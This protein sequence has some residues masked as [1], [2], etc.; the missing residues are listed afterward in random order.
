MIVGG[1]MGALAAAFELTRAPSA[2]ERL[3][4]TLLQPGWVLGGKGASTRNADE[5]HRIE[6]HGFHTWGGYYEEAFRLMNECYAELDRPRD[7]PLA[8]LSDAFEKESRLTLAEDVGGSF[9][10]WPIRMPENDAVPGYGSRLRARDYVDMARSLL[11]SRT[12]DVRGLSPLLSSL[13]DALRGLPA[14]A[15][16]LLRRA[17]I[18]TDFLRTIVKGALSDRLFER[19]A[20]SVADEDWSAWL[21]RHGGAE[22]TV[23]SPL[24][25]GMYDLL[26]AF[27]GG[28]T[29]A[30]RLSAA[31]V[32]PTVFKF[33][34]G[35]H[36]AVLWQMKAG[37]GEVV[38]APL[39][40]VLRR[41]GVRFQFFH[42]LRSLSPSHDGRSIERLTVQRSAT[43]RGGEYEPLVDLDGLPVWPHRPLRQQLTSED[44]EVLVLEKGE[45]FDAVV[46]GMSLGGLRD[47]SRDLA[48]K[49]A[50]WAA[51][52]D[53]V[54][55]V[56]TQAMQLWID[57]TSEELG[58]TNRGRVLGGYAH[59]FNTWADMSHLIPMERFGAGQVRSLA[60]L[61]GPLCDGD[62]DAE[63]NARAWLAEHGGALWPDGPPAL[64]GRIR[65]AYF[66]TNGAGS[67]RYVQSTPGSLGYRLPPD[68][69]G[70]EN[71]FLAGDWVQT[72]YNIGT[73]EAA[74]LGG[75]GAARAAADRLRERS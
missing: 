12:P 56:A 51:M 23:R 57:R 50:R 64:G 48:R 28:N 72:E 4:V 65:S 68:D 63:R 3:D 52:L 13:A 8:T 20:S 27:E 71:L 17:H 43:V 60:Y 73:I 54:P 6:E 24:V 16:D 11:S 55:T 34:M 14:R 26:F 58:W 30:P 53:H 45:H 38:F 36:G 9:R 39:Y 1:G 41:R 59:P 35:Y 19:G 25:R 44:P 62:G 75:L 49:S 5:C 42:A 15:P 32:V 33:L 47:V 21:R 74:V 7:A 40:Q 61:C 29:A 69:S 66:R 10:F 22:Q 2:R 70:F 31:G 37:M 67:E 46:L 18:S